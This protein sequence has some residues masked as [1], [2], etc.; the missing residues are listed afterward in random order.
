MISNKKT[1]R[2][3]LASSKNMS[4]LIHRITSKTKGDLYYLICLHSFRTENKLKSYE[5]LCKK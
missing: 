4:A 1:R 2:I 3:T 5:K